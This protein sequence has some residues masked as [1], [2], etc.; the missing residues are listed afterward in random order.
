MKF[1]WWPCCCTWHLVQGRIV[2]VLVLGGGVRNVTTVYR[3]LLLLLLNTGTVAI[4]QHWCY[5]RC[6]LLHYNTRARVPSTILTR[7][8]CHLNWWQE[9]KRIYWKL[10]SE[11]KIKL[12]LK[13]GGSIHLIF[14]I[15]Y[16]QFNQ[17][18]TFPILKSKLWYNLSC[19]HLSADSGSL[20]LNC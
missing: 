13:K 17:G 5:D 12:V 10:C 2:L 14:S 16:L 9:D 7:C 18:S 4:S 11:A 19:P 1:T 15:E 8:A 6:P 3:E 20:K